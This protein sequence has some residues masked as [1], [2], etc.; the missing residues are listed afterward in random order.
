MAKVNPFGLKRPPRKPETREFTDPDQPGEVFTFTLRKLDGAETMVTTEESQEQIETWVTGSR[1][2]PASQFP[3]VDG[4]EVK[5][6]EA[7]CLACQMLWAMQCPVDKNERYTFMD[8]VAM[9]VTAPTAWSRIGEWMQSILSPK[10]TA[11]GEDEK[12]GALP[13]ELTAPS[14]EPA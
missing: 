5:V 7:L 4:Q 9:S 2:R 6:T 14:S 3:F 1:D 11:M 10:I 8:L 12:G 13:T